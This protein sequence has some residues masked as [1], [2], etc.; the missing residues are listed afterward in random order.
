M[1]DTDQQSAQGNDPVRG[2]IYMALA[3]LSFAVNDAII[4]YIGVTMPVG[5]LLFVRGVFTIIIIGA[6]CWYVGALHALPQL[7]SRP[8]AWRAVADVAT[9]Y[10]FI[11]ALLNLPL[12]NANSILQAVPFLVIVLATVFLGERVGWRR[13][14][15]VAVGFA[16]VLLIV[17]PGGSDFN[18]YSLYAMAALVTVAARDIITRRI[19]A[20]VPSMI[21]ALANA[22]AVT[23]GG[24]AWGLYTGFEP[25]D[26]RQLGYLWASAMMIAA[27]Y[28]FMVLTIRTADVASS[29]PMRYT[30]VPWSILFGYLVFGDVPDLLAFAGMALIALSGVYALN[31]EA[32]LRKSGENVTHVSKKYRW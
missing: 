18:V 30:M 26:G 13:F 1:T 8:V 6:I 28:S 9:T 27:A 11:T 19:P 25:L 24:L 2:S 12:A 17:R 29:A 10:L 14:S 3:M 5:E 21:V 32:K 20:K 15:A 16:G 7:L 31:R 4:K 22:L 23:V